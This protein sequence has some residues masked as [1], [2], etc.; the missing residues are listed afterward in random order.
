MNG[1]NSFKIELNQYGG[2]VEL[3]GTGSLIGNIPG[4]PGSNRCVIHNFYLFAQIIT[5][6]LFTHI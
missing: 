5:T 3:D 1:M 2:Q 4:G 6:N